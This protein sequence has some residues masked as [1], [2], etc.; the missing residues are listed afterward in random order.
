MHPC[1][2]G[3]PNPCDKGCGRNETLRLSIEDPPISSLPSTKYNQIRFLECALSFRELNTAYRCVL[4]SSRRNASW[5]AGTSA[6]STQGMT[7]GCSMTYTVLS[8]TVC[9]Y[10]ACDWSAYT[11]IWRIF[12][13]FL[14]STKLGIFRI[15]FL[16]LTCRFQP[17][18]LSLSD[19]PNRPSRII[20]DVIRN[21]RI[22]LLL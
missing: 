11:L 15:L 2:A 5:A 9:S 4:L 6:S 3:D 13:A 8:L 10:T 22:S 20:L 21:T 17:Q 12:G 19:K 16:M 1:S 7:S 18:R 14:V